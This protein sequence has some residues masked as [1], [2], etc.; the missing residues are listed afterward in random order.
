M[1]RPILLALFVLVPQSWG[2]SA[3]ECRQVSEQASATVV[4][5][6]RAD[7]GRKYEVTPLYRIVDLKT[8]EALLDERSVLRDPTVVRRLPAGQYELHA[9]AWRGYRCGNGDLPPV[10]TVWVAPPTRVEL[11][12]GERLEWTFSFR[13]AGRLRVTASLL[14]LTDVDGRTR[15]ERPD[16]EGGAKAFPELRAIHVPSGR[17]QRL[18][19]LDSVFDLR[20]EPWPRP[21]ETVRTFE[22]LMEGVYALEVVHGERVLPQGRFTVRSGEE[23]P[24]LLDLWP[25]AHEP[26]R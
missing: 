21:W 22:P 10:R 24:L 8:G 11:E 19:F 17:V 14:A 13:R 16:D 9:R 25:W 18:T 20:R 1:L 26:E 6:F 7:G 5:S 12:P 23:T 15:W 2:A 3:S 4:L